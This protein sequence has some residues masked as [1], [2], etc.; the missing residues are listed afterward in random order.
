M[1]ATSKEDALGPS[2]AFGA[3]AVPRASRRA[4][5]AAAGIG[6]DLEVVTNLPVQDISLN[7][8]NP[9]SDLGDLESLAGSLKTHGQKTA[10]SIMSRATY[11][12]AN[13]G[14][15]NAL[16]PDTR[17]V[18]IDGNSRLDAARAAGLTT[19][20]VMVDDELGANPDELLESA[21]VANIHRKDLDHL[22]EARALEQLLKVHGGSQ[23]ALAARLHRSQGWVSQRLA[24]LTLTPELKERLVRGEESAAELRA[25]GRKPAEQQ[26]QALADIKA[27]KAAAKAASAAAVLPAPAPSA[28]PA[29]APQPQVHYAVMNPPAGTGQAAPEDPERAPSPQ[30]ASGA[31]PDATPDPQQGVGPSDTP[32]P[33]APTAV[34]PSGLMTLPESQRS[35]L[36]HEYVKHAGSVET[37]VADLARGLPA[38]RVQQLGQILRE[39]GNGM[40][41]R[42]G[43]PS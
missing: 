27:R 22:D 39:V 7:P 24:L 11:L 23:E 40:L 5:A 14:R 15:E 26:E 29:S 33:P 17:Y 20:K 12:A 36:L 30:S 21:L 13:P 19:I 31:L 41:S 34:L 8:D 43:A 3:A 38:D 10:I 16:E 35:A 32:E 6:T 37:M 2:A 9:R 42:A 4:A 18:V 25:V 28:A 1:T